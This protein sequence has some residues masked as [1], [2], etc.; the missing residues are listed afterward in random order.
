MRAVCSGCGFTATVA[1]DG[2]LMPHKRGEGVNAECLGTTPR[3]TFAATEV[4]EFERAEWIAA[5]RLEAAQFELRAAQ[6]REMMA[7]MTRDCPADC[8]E[9]V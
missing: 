2:A 3:P 7:K 6:A 4:G 1:R 9:G 5:R 8:M